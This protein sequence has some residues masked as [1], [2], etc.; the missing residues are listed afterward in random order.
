[1]TNLATNNS[2]R[3]NGRL[4]L[5]AV[6]DASDLS[7]TVQ[8]K[9]VTGRQIL[10]ATAIDWTVSKRPLHLPDGRVMPRTFALVR[11]DNNKP[12]STVGAQYTVNQNT[13]GLEAFDRLVDAGLLEGYSNAGLFD[14]GKLV[15]VQAQMKTFEI[16]PDEMRGYLTLM[17]SH[18]SRLTDRWAPCIT[19]V[20]CRNT[21]MMAHGEAKESGL[22]LRHT[23]SG[24]A[25]YLDTV[26]RIKRAT[27]TLDAFTRQASTLQKKS[28]TRAQ[29]VNLA[30]DLMPGH[31]E[32]ARL[33]G[34]RSKVID[35][36]DNGTGI[37]GIAGTKWAAF[38]AVTEYVDHHRSTRRSDESTSEDSRLSSAWFGSG[39]KLKAKAFEILTA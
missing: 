32:S 15:W 21:F 39:A 33:E 9:S 12:L 38:N 20:V 5:S 31:S 3:I 19:R 35:L 30:A 25:L 27:G 13:D 16:G 10:N 22:T 18:G 26:E 1:M 6:D 23:K 36:Y 4:L 11:D 24:N 2:P 7:M 29:M 37:H 28:F 34:M 8:P 17:I 14:G